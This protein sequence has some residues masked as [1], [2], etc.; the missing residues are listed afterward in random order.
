M[1][2]NN[3]KSYLYLGKTF[4]TMPCEINLEA[5]YN[6]NFPGFKCLNDIGNIFYQP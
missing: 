1:L 4:N 3:D 2:G 5:N 6:G